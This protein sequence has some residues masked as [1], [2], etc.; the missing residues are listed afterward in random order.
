MKKTWKRWLGTVAAA[1]VTSTALAQS[2]NGAGVATLR[3]QSPE[4]SEEGLVRMGHPSASATGRGVR[5]TQYQPTI[6][7][8]AV[9]QD[10]RDGGGYAPQ[11]QDGA[12]PQ[13]G[14]DYPTQNDGGYQNERNVP[15]FAPSRSINDVQWRVG[16][17]ALNTLGYK[18]E[19]TN[20]NAFIPI[21][22]DDSQNLL[23]FVPRVNF[24][25]SGNVNTG[26]VGGSLGLGLRHFDPANH[27]IYGIS[28][29]WDH[30]SGHQRA[31]NQAGLSLES[32]GKYVSTR[33]NANVPIEK[34]VDITSAGSLGGP[35]F[36]NN[37][38][39]YFYNFQRET[40]FQ[41]YQL[42]LASPIPLLGRYGAEWA[43]SGY[44]LVPNTAVAQ[45]SAGIAGRV[46]LQVSEDFWINATFSNDKIYGTN[47]GINFE[48]TLPNGPQTRWLRLNRSR[49]KMLSSVRRTYRVSSAIDDIQE[50]KFFLNPKD[51]SPIQVAHIDPEAPSVGT[52]AVLNP[53]GSVADYMA[54]PARAAFDIIYVG[55]NAD[56]SDTDLNTG[57]EVLDCQRLLGTGT[58]A[59]GS[60][61][62]FATLDRGDGGTL[63]NLPGFGGNNL[64]STG[65]NPLLSNSGNVGTPVV[66][67]NGNYT[68]VSGFTIDAGRTADGIATVDAALVPRTVDSFVVTNNTI[69]SAFTAINI[70]SDTTLLAAPVASTLPPNRSQGFGENIGIVAN[71][72][73]DGTAGPTPGVGDGI[74]I[75]QVNG[76]GADAL[77][78]S[79]RNNTI[80]GL[81]GEDID[82]DG[83]SDVLEDL[84]GNGIFDPG[85][86]DVD[87]D[88]NP[89]VLEDVNGNAVLDPGRA[90]IVTA[91]AGTEILADQSAASPFT[92]IL[93]NTI[94]ASGTGVLMTAL[95][96]SHIQ[97]DVL[98]N[99][100]T[101]ST[102]AL[103]GGM[104]YNADGGVIDVDTFSTNTV[105]G[106]AGQGVAFTATNAGAINF[107]DP[108]P[109]GPGHL[110]ADP[111]IFN[112]T[113]TG[114]SRSGLEL[115]ANG[116]GSTIDVDDITTNTITGNGGPTLN[117]L[118]PNNDQSNVFISAVAGGNVTIDNVT[119]NTI[120]G[121]VAGDGITILSDGAASVVDFDIGTVAGP[122]NTITGNT[123]GSGIAVTTQ[124][125]ASTAQGSIINNTL[126]ANGTGISLT[127]LSGLIDMNDVGANRIILNNQINGNTDF[128]V[129]IFASDDGTGPGVIDALIRDGS[130]SNNQGIGVNAIADTDATLDLVIGGNAV[131]TDLTLISGNQDAGVRLS[132]SDTS[133]AS[134]L[135][136]NTTIVGTTNDAL[137][138][139]PLRGDGV[140]ITAEDDSVITSLVIGDPVL[141]NTII[142]GPAAGTGNV[143]N[144]V[145]VHTEDN[146]Q[147]TGGINIQNTSI[148]RNGLNGV[149]IEKLNLSQIPSVN[150]LNVSATSNT[151]DGVNMILN[152]DL[153]VDPLV[154]NILLNV[155]DG[156]YN[157]NGDDGIDVIAQNNI[158]LTSN[159]GTTTGVL[160]QD[161]TGDGLIHQ[162]DG[163]ASG[164]ITWQNSTFLSNTASG[165]TLLT[166]ADS[167]VTGT[168]GGTG[169][170]N[171]FQEN[172]VNGYV[173]TVDNQAQQG[174][175]LN[176]IL[177]QDNDFINN[178]GNAIDL[179]VLLT[180]G[181]VP[182]LLN[183]TIDNNRIDGSTLAGID[184]NAQSGDA[185]IIITD[186]VIGAVT[187]NNEGINLNVTGI[188]A[189]VGVEHNV[190]VD[191]N[192][193]L[194]SVTTGVDITVEGGSLTFTAGTN[195][196]NE[197]L[198]SGQDGM[199]ISQ[200]AGVFVGTLQNNL[201]QDSGDNGIEIN[202][203]GTASPTLLILNP[204]LLTIDTNDILQNDGVGI[205]A[206]FT[207]TN[208]L[209]GPN[210]VDKDFQGDDV[211]FGVLTVNGFERHL[212]ITN[213]NTIQGSG[214]EGIFVRTETTGVDN[215]FDDRQTNPF[216]Q[217][218]N[219]QF[220]N[221]QTGPNGAFNNY[222]DFDDRLRAFIEIGQTGLLNGNT[223]SG[224]GRLIASHG[225][226]L[227]VGSNTLMQVDYSDNVMSGNQLTDFFTA[228]FRSPLA[229]PANPNASSLQDSDTD[230]AGA[231][232]NNPERIF[233][234]DVAELRLQFTDNLGESMAQ[235]QKNSLNG[236]Y[237]NADNFK[238]FREFGY[239][240]VDD[241][242]GGGLDAPNN[243]FSQDFT[244]FGATSV[245][246][247]FT[248]ANY[249]GP[250]PQPLFAP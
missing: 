234:D 104:I 209:N 105:T 50:T 227:E 65:A 249:F 2:P 223:I 238:V 49:E 80:T 129:N 153:T 219:V 150:L 221:S 193:I 12:P 198:N 177:L 144:G 212:I 54:D 163:A 191:N 119:D 120:T 23:F 237:S 197:I 170:G 72:T 118:L 100:V 70:L 214:E 32:L 36:Q 180:A 215:T 30:D 25:S 142:G 248:A 73:I 35:F 230:G 203:S 245:D 28:G 48:L 82:G 213:N 3:S 103:S 235:V 165:A 71:N 117:P 84:N 174:P 11:N 34:S 67:I 194:N 188:G 208:V 207:G 192:L 111:T 157:L 148:A 210:G 87:G 33:F 86:V 92:G 175:L 68:E 231:D 159:I 149:F 217:G 58:L 246:D 17:Q 10:Y 122:V 38:I 125:G 95:A 241:G 29:W 172:G 53:F 139:P 60:V 108:L 146:A 181:P 15:N 74:N 51:G 152:N 160:F 52:G 178:I 19:M 183:Y 90:I 64:Q 158:V 147:I 89:D 185:N 205:A 232:I 112:N 109:I 126:S 115:T 9:F 96:G 190:V 66:R 39:A 128:G 199:R 243:F 79:I 113:I 204:F 22:S 7:P 247:I 225:T 85:E 218:P 200:S 47:T 1:L 101:G 156:Q 56:G 40:S 88:G 77:N 240:R 63:F 81:I 239:F 154:T 76:T 110:V 171:T 222:W 69:Q 99:T 55:R 62:Q 16:H 224:S 13:G 24:F 127:A 189:G 106:G 21:M 57:I 229:A 145:E 132:T 168:V 6:D 83:N 206:F 169:T 41:N 195:A 43:V 202:S 59:D 135:I 8:N 176:P 196:R 173:G 228:S 14:G 133:D 186:N 131:A 155:Q 162:F 4:Y 44:A 75:T 187:A 93:D 201:I 137:T 250:V 98:R 184:L 102:D 216:N 18:G 140:L 61:H 20:L 236:A 242:T 166:R 143:G 94:T 136:T 26:D 78:L 167:I 45:N 124:N 114:N 161:N 130:I 244:T 141:Q 134:L 138:L 121:A 182:G 179:N 37:N 211:P 151:L 5:Q 42:E 226:R 164:T 123:L 27:R 46:E 97:L 233:Y 31:Y 107:A 116:A 91:N 220:A